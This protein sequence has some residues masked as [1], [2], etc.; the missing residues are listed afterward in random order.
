MA[1][2]P[3]L[4]KSRIASWTSWTFAHSGAS[5]P[6]GTTSTALTRGS[7]L[8]L[9]RCSSTARNPLGRLPSNNCATPFGGHLVQVVVEAQHQRGVATDRRRLADG[10][11][12]DRDARHRDGNRQEEQP[13]DEPHTTLCHSR[14]LPWK[15][16]RSS[17]Y[18][19]LARSRPHLRRKGLDGLWRGLV[20][21]KALLVEVSPSCGSG[22]IGRRASLRS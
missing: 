19:R 8:A 4:R 14:A 20:G 2:L 18:R 1:C 5:M 13:E 17:K 21:L 11:V 9:R 12:H 22:G 7:A 16:P 10:E 3:D 15:P 6:A